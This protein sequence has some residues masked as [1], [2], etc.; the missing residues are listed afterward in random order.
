MQKSH[1]KIK[2]RIFTNVVMLEIGSTPLNPPHCPPM[3]TKFSF[4]LIGGT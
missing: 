2:R 3:A 4:V 1:G